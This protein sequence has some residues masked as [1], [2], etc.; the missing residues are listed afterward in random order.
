MSRTASKLPGC[1]DFAAFTQPWVAR[2]RSTRRLVG[3][4]AVISRGRQV[5]FDIE[6]GSFLPHMVRRLAGA[7]VE[8][9]LGKRMDGEFER[10]LREAR[11]GEASFTAPARGL[12]LIRIRYESGLFD[13]ETDEDLQP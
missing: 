6:A 4:A 8:V 5:L 1:H 7:L 3:A 10:L 13:D 12:C 9:G 2:A 11:P